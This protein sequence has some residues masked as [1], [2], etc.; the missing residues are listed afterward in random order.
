MKDKTPWSVNINGNWPIP[1]RVQI[2]KTERLV[3]PVTVLESDPHSL[4]DR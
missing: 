4:R 2:R 1:T 3:L